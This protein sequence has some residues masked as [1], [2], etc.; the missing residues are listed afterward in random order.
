MKFFATIA[1]LLA[2]TE[3]IKLKHQ[4]PN[5]N[6]LLQVR[7]DECSELDVEFAF[8]LF[9]Q[10][11][12]DGDGFVTKKEARKQLK[13][14]GKDRKDFV[15]TM[16]KIWDE[17]TGDDT[18]LTIAEFEAAIKKYEV[19][20]NDAV[21]IAW[22]LKQADKGGNNNDQ[23]EVEEAQALGE[24]LLN[25]DWKQVT[26][27][28]MAG[29]KDVAGDDNKLTKEEVRAALEAE[30]CPLDDEGEDVAE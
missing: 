18:T 25:A 26:K 3:A 13:K 1:T 10:A 9:D 12:K 27:H 21:I 5:P 24:A 16:T 15:A 4:S 22:L 17:I 28:V 11:N 6:F 29:W 2:S 19:G 14:M 8:A 30:G 7:E 23:V 20:E